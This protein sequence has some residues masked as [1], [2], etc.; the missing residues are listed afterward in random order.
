MFLVVGGY[1][2]KIYVLDS[3]SWSPVATLELSARIPPSVAVWREPSKWMETTEG[4]GFLSYERLQGTHSINIARADPTKPNPKRGTVQLEW[5][6]TGSLLMARFENITSAVHIF[7]FP[8]SQAQF[9]PRLR[10]VLLHARPILHARWNP[11]RKGS[12]A[13]C[14]R[15]QSVYT[16][17]D[18]WVGEGGE[19]EMAECIGIPAKNFETRDLK[20]APDGKGIVL[21]GREQFCCAFE[22]EEY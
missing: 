18:E 21:L 22:V 13:L 9:S 10:S 16:W 17:S 3:L 20:W 7:D 14:T 6:T 5:N 19:E 12:L 8:S 11:V 15:G 1:D 2:D 4:R